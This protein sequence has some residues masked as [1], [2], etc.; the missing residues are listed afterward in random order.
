MVRKQPW[1]VGAALAALGANLR[2]T[3]REFTASELAGWAPDFAKTPGNAGLALERLVRH[4]LVEQLDGSPEKAARGPIRIKHYVLTP[5]GLATCRAAAQAV[6]DVPPPDPMALTT[7]LWNLLRMRRK[8]TSDEAAS[9][10]VD[11]G[12]DEV[13]ESTR[14]TLAGY[15]KTWAQVAPDVVQVSARRVGGFKA[16]VLLKDTGI[17]PPRTKTSR[18]PHAAAPAAYAP[19]AD[20]RRKVV[21]E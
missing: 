8:L 14:H 7:R 2:N 19:P 3:T 4:E 12:S 17:H 5:R 10:L 11:A 18:I 20:A 9:L 13:M 6:H 1:F 15:L 16:Y 21:T